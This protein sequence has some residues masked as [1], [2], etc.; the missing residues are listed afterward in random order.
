MKLSKYDLDTYATINFYYNE[1]LNQIDRFIANRV[2]AELEIVKKIK[3]YTLDFKTR[4]YVSDKLN[5]PL[6]KAPDLVIRVWYIRNF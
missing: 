1:Y 3:I 6:D 5:L 4:L 2:L